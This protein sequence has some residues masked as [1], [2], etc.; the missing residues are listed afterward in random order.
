[1]R[2]SHLVFVLVAR[3]THKLAPVLC[4]CTINQCYVLTMKINIH[5][6]CTIDSVRD[7]KQWRMGTGFVFLRKDWIV[8]AKHVVWDEENQNVRYPMF[9]VSTDP[10]ITNNFIQPKKIFLHPDI[11]L[12]VLEATSEVGTQPLYPAHQNIENNDHVVGI[13]YSPDSSSFSNLQFKAITLR[14]I[15]KEVRERDSGA[16]TLYEFEFEGSEQGNSGGPIFGDGAGV[17]AVIGHGIL[18][19]DTGMSRIRA[20]SIQTV[21]DSLNLELMRWPEYAVRQLEQR[22]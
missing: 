3:S 9:L 19:E 15:D 14:N 4:A 12:A 10:N 22:T 21:I 17:L 20:T 18:N 2:V 1:M 5:S 7:G 13:G 16:E 8:T 11:D 6:L